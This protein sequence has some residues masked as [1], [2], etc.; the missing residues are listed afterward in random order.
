MQ[1]ICSIAMSQSSPL[2]SSDSTELVSAIHARY[3]DVEEIGKGA[4]GVVVSARNKTNGTREAVKVVQKSQ[5][6]RPSLKASLGL[7]IHL[8]RTL[9]HPN[10]ISFR[11]V[12]EDERSFYIV[13]ELGV[14]GTLLDRVKASKKGLHEI[15]GLKIFRQVMSA[16][17]YMHNK[18]GV[19]HKDVKLENIV[20]MEK[21]G[22]VVKLID[23]GLSHS[24]FSRPASTGYRFVGTGAYMAPELLR[25]EDLVPEVAEMWTCGTLLF[26]ILT[27]KALVKSMP[28]PELIKT[29]E[30]FDP[31]KRV[32]DCLS[33][34]VSP[35]TRALLKSMLH[36]DPGQRPT[37]TQVVNTLENILYAGAPPPLVSSPLVSH[38]S[39]GFGDGDEE[40]EHWELD[41]LPCLLTRSPI[42]DEE[43][44]AQLQSA[45]DLGRN[46][47][48]D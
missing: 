10:I 43:A 33:K 1:N 4:F 28:T 46:R 38:D 14:G 12:F 22:R 2:T 41:G 8:L 26:G 15:S 19:T 6:T 45:L 25:K 34:R 7:E 5:L 20:L 18:K 37:A 13:T 42:S 40:K 44:S 29:M 17:E 31:D 30:S 47:A 21:K 16:V 48:S 32:D 3:Q 36:T 27:C 23:F 35:A 24:R 11:E 39:E 9:K